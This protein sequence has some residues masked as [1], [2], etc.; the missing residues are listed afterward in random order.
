MLAIARVD[1]RR[2]AL[3]R[4]NRPISGRKSTANASRSR[5]RF[6]AARLDA[7]GAGRHPQF[8]DTGHGGRL[9]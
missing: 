1:E 2:A 7:A 6:S 8:N 9:L 5:T 3:S 4:D